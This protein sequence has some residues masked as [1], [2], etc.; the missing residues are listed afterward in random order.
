[1]NR[2]VI[3]ATLACL[4]AGLLPALSQNVP[5]PAASFEVA[6]IKPNRSGN[7]VSG[8]CHGTDSKPDLDGTSP[9]IPLGRCW[10]RS[11]RL[12]H[13]IPIAY[14]IQIKDLKGG[15]EW[16]WGADRFDLEGK[17]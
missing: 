16:V 14:T 10:I 11:A 4:M 3:L 1:M 8:G 15:P 9:A 5:P 6:S 7:G 2:V 17:A 12:S 13:L